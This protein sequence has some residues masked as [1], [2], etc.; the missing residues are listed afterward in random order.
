MKLM[1]AALAL[2]AFTQSTFAQAPKE[3][4]TKNNSWLKAGLE[5]GL[6]VGNTSDFSSVTA[7]VVVSGQWMATPNFGLGLTSGYT[8]YFAKSNFKDIGVI[9]VGLLLR[10]YPQAQGF[11]AGADA[12]YSFITNVSD[13]TGGAYVKPQIGYHDYN[14][15]LYGF[16][17][18]VFVNKGITDL[19]SVGI[20]ATYNLRFNR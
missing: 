6:P 3:E 13:V 16:Y 4:I 5:V 20:A 10:Y 17:N 19:Q 7:G 1:T 9:P 11:F 2:F 18:H 12:G 14:W 8:N 15:N